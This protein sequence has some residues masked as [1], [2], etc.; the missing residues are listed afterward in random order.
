MTDEGLNGVDIH[1]ANDSPEP[2][3]GWLRVAL[4][5]LGEHK[6]AEADR[7]ITLAEHQASTFGV[8]EVLGRFV[9]AACAYRFGPPGHDLIVASLHRSRGDVPFAQSFRFPA[10]RPTR[11]VPITEMGIAAEARLLS[12]GVID[13]LLRSQRF[14]WGTRL[15]APGFKPSDAYF[16]IEPG[17]QRRLRLMPLRGGERPFE[18]ILTAVNADGHLPIAIGSSI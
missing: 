14:A 10:G 4:Y 15:T 6:V 8:E 16:G 7:P 3:G 18:A 11:T 17:G 13:V 1:V 9:D 12:D 5:R 2:L